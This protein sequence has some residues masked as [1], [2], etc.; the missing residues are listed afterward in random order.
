M[1][2]GNTSKDGTGTYYSLLVDSDGRQLIAGAAAEDAAAAGN[3]ALIGGRYDA[4]ARTLD[5]G[6]AGALALDAAGRAMVVG[7][8]AEDAAAAGNPVLV[9]GRY[10]SSAR[11]LETG[12]VGAPALDVAGRLLT[13]ENGKSGHS[14]TLLTADGDIKASAGVLY[15]L[16]ITG[17]GVTAGDSVDIED[18]TTN[19][20]VF[21]FAAANETIVFT[22]S[23]PISFATSIHVDVTIS[24]GAINVS[25]VYD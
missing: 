2:T 7:V 12:D 14:I 19:K 21:V 25:G 4:S 3:P 6:D 10:D 13:T 11:T 22:P 9:G 16:V 23:V 18:N 20:L 5:D 8:A 24:G 17:I 15:A 1:A